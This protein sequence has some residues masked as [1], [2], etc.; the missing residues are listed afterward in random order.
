MGPFDQPL[1]KKRTAQPSL[2][3]KQPLELRAAKPSDAKPLAEVE[4]LS[5]HKLQKGSDGKFLVP[6]KAVPVIDPDFDVEV[7]PAFLMGLAGFETLVHG[8]G[9]NAR[10][11]VL[12][13]G[14]EVVGCMAYEVNR[15]MDIIDVGAILIHPKIPAERGM[16]KFQAWLDGLG[17]EALHEFEAVYDLPDAL[18]TPMNRIFTYL[19]GNHW[20]YKLQPGVYRPNVDAWRFKRTFGSDKPQKRREKAA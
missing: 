13:R 12:T 8:V 15:T 5:F 19:K 1:N 6:H 20:S 10:M 18:D 7:Q 17:K 4:R 14:E 2:P 3:A 11:V 9:R 16:E